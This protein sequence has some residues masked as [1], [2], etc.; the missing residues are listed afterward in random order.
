MDTRRYVY[1]EIGLL[2]QLILSILGSVLNE[3]GKGLCEAR[4]FRLDCYNKFRL[5]YVSESW[6]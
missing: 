4:I 1:D 5:Y 2:A 6:K 3:T